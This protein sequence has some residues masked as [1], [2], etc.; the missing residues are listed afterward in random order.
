LAPKTKAT[1]KIKRKGGTEQRLFKALAHPLR[2]QALMILNERIAS[3]NELSKE[4]GEGLGQVSYHV[5]VLLESNCIELVRTTPRR[6][7]VEHY[8]RATSRAFLDDA[9]WAK[10]PASVKPGFSASLLQTIMDDAVTSLKAGT[11]DARDEHHLSWTPVKVDEEGWRDLTEA[12]AETLD[13]VLEI[14]AESARR[15]AKAE[16]EGSISA[17][18][19]MMNF[20]A[21]ASKKK[22]AKPR[23]A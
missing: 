5:K 1:S 12:L 22:I 20:E 15:M 16:D 18:V 4:L 8:Y 14:Q 11:F 9:E 7:A 17:T 6:G 23:S 21:P 2:F 19:A 3:P 10:L 13:R